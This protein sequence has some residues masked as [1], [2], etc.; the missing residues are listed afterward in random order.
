[1][2]QHYYSYYE[3]YDSTGNYMFGG[4]GSFFVNDAVSAT[5]A[6]VDNHLQY[7]LSI[8]QQYNTNVNRVV[9]KMLTKL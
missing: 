6:D 2:Q 5:S 9:L 3:A 1:M 7:L 4:N 8:A